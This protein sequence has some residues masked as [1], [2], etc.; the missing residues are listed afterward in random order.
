MREVADDRFD[1]GRFQG[2]ALDLGTNRIEASGEAAGLTV[3]WLPTGWQSAG[4]PVRK[5][6]FHRARP[7]RLR[8]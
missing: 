6:R 7:R 5:A 4:T 1:L 3:I 8:P 2:P